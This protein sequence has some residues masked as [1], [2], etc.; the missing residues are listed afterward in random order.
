MTYTCLQTDATRFTHLSWD[1]LK[2]PCPAGIMTTIP[3][4][5][6]W[7]GKN[8]DSPNHK[9]HVAYP[10]GAYDRG[11]ECP[12]SHPVNIPQ[13]VMEIRWDTARFNDAGLWPVESGRQPFLWSY[14]DRVG[15][16]HH[17]D[18]LFGWKG[19]LLQR[20]FDRMYCPYSNGCGMLER[21]TV[22]KSN[23]CTQEASVKVEIDGWLEKMPGG[24]VGDAW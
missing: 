13:I 3:F 15:H 7:D 6:C 9:S 18:Y 1:F 22:L 23:E 11:A 8:L 14:G 5:P 17:A 12:A 20:F 19:D 4:P 10:D 24:V 16:G 21:S 2:T